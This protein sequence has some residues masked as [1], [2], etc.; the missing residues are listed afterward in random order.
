MIGLS[1]A[2]SLLLVPQE[3]VLWPSG[4]KGNVAGLIKAEDYPL[5]AATRGAEGTARVDLAID[6]HGKVTGC[7]VAQSAGDASLDEA[8]CRLLIER[9][10]FQP[11]RDAEGRAIADTYRT[12]ITWRLDNSTP[13]EPLQEVGTLHATADGLHQCTTL[14]NGVTGPPLSR[15]ACLAGPD[16]KWSRL[17]D[18]MKVPG[19][20]TTVFA[21]TPVG[22]APFPLASYGKRAA[23][24]EAEVSIAASGEPSACRISSSQ[25]QDVWQP[26][27]NAA[28][29]CAMF[30]QHM[31]FDAFEGGAPRRAVLTQSLYVDMEADR[32][33]RPAEP[34]GNN[35]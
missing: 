32:L 22:Q 33:F 20:I 15:E 17:L 2:L 23:H 5:E 30:F 25:V 27:A 11:A 16:A 28:G 19:R 3:E 4:A 9:A 14:F 29:L 18:E 31:R 8:T 6:P 34:G 24:M 21:F 7:A 26:T 13:F 35:R 12:T 1:V 10:T